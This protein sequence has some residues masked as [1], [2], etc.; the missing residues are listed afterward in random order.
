MIKLI[1]IICFVCLKQFEF[2]WPSVGVYAGTHAMVVRRERQKLFEEFIQANENWA[3]SS[4]VLNN[5]NTLSEKQRGVYKLF[6]KE[7]TV[8]HKRVLSCYVCRFHFHELVRG[9]LNST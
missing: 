8:L 9:G 4:I 1:T 2:V 6:S 3:D 7:D 5:R